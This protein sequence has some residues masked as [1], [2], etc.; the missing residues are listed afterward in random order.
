M[1]KL[2]VVRSGPARGRIE[3]MRPA[4]ESDL[5]APPRSG[6]AGWCDPTTDPAAVARSRDP[7]RGPVTGSRAPGTA[8]YT[9][10]HAHPDCVTGHSVAHVPPVSVR[11]RSVLS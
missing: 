11:L 8:L 7:E 1:V 6:R 3:G 2:L 5:P 4:R 10:G 9:G